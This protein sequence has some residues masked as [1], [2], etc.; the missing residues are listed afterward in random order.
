[1]SEPQKTHL[2]S[3]QKMGAHGRLARLC[4]V[5]G[6]A[7]SFALVKVDY[8]PK[9]KVSKLKTAISLEQLDGNTKLQIGDQNF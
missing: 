2:I 1:M 9:T 6:A 7:A 4:A 8:Q 3:L 5:G